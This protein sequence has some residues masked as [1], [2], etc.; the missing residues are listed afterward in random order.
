MS[1][2]KRLFIEGHVMIRKHKNEV[3]PKRVLKDLKIRVKGMTV[4]Q[5]GRPIGEI[6]EAKVDSEGLRVK[7]RLQDPPALCDLH[8]VYNEENDGSF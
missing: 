2:E 8:K 3:I 7:I 5:S 6:E 4:L 1:E